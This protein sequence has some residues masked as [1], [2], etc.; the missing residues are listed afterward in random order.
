[1]E[2]AQVNKIGNDD[3]YIFLLGASVLIWN[4]A[5][6]NNFDSLDY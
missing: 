5:F 2:N 6:Q 4:Y 3:I 1:M